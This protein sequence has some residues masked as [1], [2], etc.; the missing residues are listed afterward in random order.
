MKYKPFGADICLAVK[1]FTELVI[2]A[3]KLLK[4]KL[5]LSLELRQE[6]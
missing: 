1:V 2:N 5:N 6:L 4:G 3:M